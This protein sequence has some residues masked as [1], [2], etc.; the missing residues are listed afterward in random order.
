MKKRALSLGICI[1][2]WN[3]GDLLKASFKSLMG[4]LSGITAAVWIFDNGSE[5]STREIIQHL[6]YGRHRIF[7]VFL[8][9]NMGIP[10]VV[11]SFCQMV[12]QDCNYT[13]HLAPEFIMLM[14]S[15][16]YFKRPI[17][18]LLRILDSNSHFAIVSGHDSIEHPATATYTLKIG[19]RKLFF[20]EKKIE[21]M[22]CMVMRRSEL[23]LCCPFPHHRIA[24][25]DWELTQWNSNSLAKRKRKLISVDSV[26]HIG[27]YDSTWNQSGVPASLE[28]MEEINKI[29][30]K[31]HLLTPR[32]TKTYRR[33]VRR[34]E[35]TGKF[36]N[37]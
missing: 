24:D 9:E 14:D 31:H 30:K 7:K 12:A 33:F 3:R 29:L 2:V 6:S 32:R 21:R 4:A 35:E 19:R 25:V 37:G 10:Y 18:D 5:K 11:N 13:G 36:W 15:D 20:K 8:P 22:C 26:A 1:P 16:V 34:L 17:K 27:L 23:E 28:Q